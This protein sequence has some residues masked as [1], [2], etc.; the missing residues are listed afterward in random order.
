MSREGD[1]AR[2]APIEL[3]LG[4]HFVHGLLVGAPG[5]LDLALGLQDVGPRDH[6]GRLGFGD[7]ATGR[8]DGGLLLRA[9]E[10]ENRRALLDLAAQ[11]EIDLGDPPVGLRKDRDGPEEDVAFVV[12]GWL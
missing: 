1:V 4:L 11:A 10:P 6:H 3:L 5:L 7:L 9:V 2:V 8:L 12:D